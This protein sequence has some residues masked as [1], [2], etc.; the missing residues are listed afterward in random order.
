MTKWDS[1]KAWYYLGNPQST[2]QGDALVAFKQHD[3]Y[4]IARTVD[5]KLSEFVSVKDFGAVLDGV[6]DDHDAVLNA[7][8]SAYDSGRSL[9]F[10]DGICFIASQ[11]LLGT[12]STQTGQPFTMFGN[13]RGSII[14]AR[15]TI[16]GVFKFQGANPESD[17]AGNRGG[18]IVV[19]DIA[20]MGPGSYGGAKSGRA[21][22]FYGIQGIEISGAYFTGWSEALMLHNVDLVTIYGASQFQSNNSGIVTSGTG[23]ATNNGQVNSFT[24]MGCWFNNNSTQGINY[25]GGSKPTIIGNNFSINGSSLVVGV[26]SE[27]NHVVVSPTIESNYFEGDTGTM[28]S[29]GGANGIVRGG[30]VRNNSMLVTASTTAITCG[31]ISNTGSVGGRLRI[32]D[33]SMSVS[34]GVGSFT[35]INQSTS[36]ETADYN[37]PNGSLYEPGSIISF[38]KTVASAASSDILK[39]GSYAA[40]LKGSLGVTSTSTGIATTKNYEISLLGSGTPPGFLL[41][42]SQNYS[43]GASA[44]TLSETQDS[45]VAGTNKLTLTNNSAAT[46]IFTCVLRID[47][48]TGTLTLL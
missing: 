4:A 17:G 8:N 38:T 21:L 46:C 32:M 11:V 20:F 10:P 44:F 45:P 34:G 16:D 5:A 36:A 12:T 25:V 47:S 26:T 27:A 23:Y 2:A 13:G 29:L 3:P 43:G 39:F 6:T 37:G 40:V 18:R 48:I 1:T 9:Y 30:S 41:T 7:A 15:A 28:I 14:S 31:N 33:N 35:E 19:R 24:V 42:S 22:H